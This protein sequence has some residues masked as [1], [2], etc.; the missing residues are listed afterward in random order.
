MV[1]EKIDY[2]EK[3]FLLLLL[4]V[5]SFLYSTLDYFSGGVLRIDLASFSINF[6]YSIVTLLIIRF[7]VDYLD[8]TVPWKAGIKKRFLIQLSSTLLLYL[9]IQSMILFLIEPFSGN[10][11]ANRNLIIISF[12]LGIAFIFIANAIY[13]LLYIEYDKKHPS[14][15]SSDQAIP[16]QGF[17]VGTHKGSR[18]SIPI[19]TIVHISIENTLTISTTDTDK[20]IILQES[21]TDLEPLLD[22]SIFFR[23]NRQ[24]IITKAVVNQVEYLDN[25]TCLVI[26]NNGERII[27]SR[28]KAPL[29]KK[30]IS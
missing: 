4:V 19:S 14:Q 16:D 15:E 8:K 24:N 1:S 23:A 9:I 12:I 17:L 5:V 28:Y 22:Q 18:I 29:F 6:L 27:V 7:F 26:L 3:W 21:L 11:I 2:Q 13:L 25:K 20:R 30:W 10:D